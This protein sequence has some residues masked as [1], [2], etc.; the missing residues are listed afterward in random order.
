MALARSQSLTT[1]SFFWGLGAA[2]FAHVV[3]L[4]SVSYFDQIHVI[5]WGS[6]AIISSSTADFLASTNPVPV[7]PEMTDPEMSEAPA[8]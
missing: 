8:V 7:E 6:L 4:F 2:L 1:D 3:A 5:W